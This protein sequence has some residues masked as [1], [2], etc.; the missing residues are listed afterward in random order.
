MLK[1]IPTFKK[2]K[3]KAVMSSELKFIQESDNIMF[4]IWIFFHNKLKQICFT[5]RKFVIELCI[6]GYLY[7]NYEILFS[8]GKFVIFAANNL[9][10]TSLSQHP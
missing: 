2:L 1:K 5:H 6:P 7:S 9:C 3:N 8:R 10:K 4:I